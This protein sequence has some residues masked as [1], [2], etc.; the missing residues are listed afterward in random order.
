MEQKISSA[1]EFRRAAAARARQQAQPLTLP[2]G[3]VV[4]ARRL[5]PMWYIETLGRLPQDVAAKIAPQENS[6]PLSPES[7]TCGAQDLIRL[8]QAIVIEPRLSLAPGADE[9]SP[10]DISDEDLAAILAY[11]RGETP[12]A[13]FPGAGAG[14]RPAAPGA[15]GTL[16]ELPPFDPVRAERHYSDPD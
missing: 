5:D 7:L 8:V 10:H 3:L 2:S 16:V 14:S 11:G 4:L 13:R 12:L 6:G 15:D 1:E 9:I